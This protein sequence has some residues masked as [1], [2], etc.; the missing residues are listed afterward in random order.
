MGV[1]GGGAYIILPWKVYVKPWLPNKVRQPSGFCDAMVGPLL[2]E[3]GALL[4]SHL[5][6]RLE[7]LLKSGPKI[8]LS[9][10]DSGNVP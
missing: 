3:F 6:C 1:G 10:C 7:R 8:V 9:V 5:A 2:T 4:G